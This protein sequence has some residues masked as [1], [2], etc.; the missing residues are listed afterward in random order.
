MLA[1]CLG[2]RR[3]ATNW[4]RRPGRAPRILQRSSDRWCC[5][6]RRVSAGIEATAGPSA[7]LLQ[8]SRLEAQRCW[9]VDA[10]TRAASAGRGASEARE[11]TA[12]P[13][14]SAPAALYAKYSYCSLQQ[15]FAK[16]SP[17]T[18]TTRMLLSPSRSLVESEQRL[19]GAG[20]RKSRAGV[21][22]GAAR[23]AAAGRSGLAARPGKTP[24]KRVNGEEL[25]LCA[26]K[27]DLTTTTS[28]VV[29]DCFLEAVV[30]G[31]LPCML[32]DIN[33]AQSRV[34]SP[35]AR[36]RRLWEAINIWCACAGGVAF[37]KLLPF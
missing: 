21:Q 32:Q 30:G 26:Q 17:R 18:T 2:E 4:K 12:G 10:S 28:V 27:L 36:S 19:G 37:L 22:R 6:G 31:Q 20:G 34:P 11:A 24:R 7:S 13:S 35:Q 33:T 15:S 8:R 3:R 23:A 29:V 25:E 5:L 9:Y 16:I 1:R 14:A